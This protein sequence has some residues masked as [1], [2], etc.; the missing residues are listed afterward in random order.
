[1]SEPLSPV[2]T[3]DECW[4]FL[5]TQE[6]GRLATAVGGHPE[7][8]PLNFTVA[9]HHVYFRTKPGTKLAE[10]AVNSHVALEA[11]RWDETVALSVVVRGTAR[12]LERDAE[13][14]AAEATGLVSYVEDGKDVWVRISPTE[15]TGR[16]L[17]RD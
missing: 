3:T 15:I 7:I 17:V 13:V 9:D 11:D 6:I 16:R 2:L 12:I 4:E 8:F 10:V 14:A 5:A 1:M